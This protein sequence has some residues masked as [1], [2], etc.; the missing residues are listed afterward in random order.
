MR[1]F[2]AAPNVRASVMTFNVWGSKHW[3]ERARALQ[4]TIKTINPDILCL[5]GEIVSYNNI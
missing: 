2:K 5:Q 4:S 1:G 3:P